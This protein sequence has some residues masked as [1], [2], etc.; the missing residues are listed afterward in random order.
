MEVSQE[1][2]VSTCELLLLRGVKT[3]V[4]THMATTAEANCQMLKAICALLSGGSTVAEAVWST[5]LSHKSELR[6]MTSNLMV[7]GVPG[8]VNGGGGKDKKG[9]KGKK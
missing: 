4:S 3:V 6:H 1:N 5:L 7:S 9:A 8:M 2:P